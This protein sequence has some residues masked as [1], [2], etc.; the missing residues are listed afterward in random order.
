MLWQPHYNLMIDNNYSQFLPTTNIKIIVIALGLHTAA[1]L[2]QLCKNLMNNN[3]CGQFANVGQF[4][5]IMNIKRIV[6][7]LG[8]HINLFYSL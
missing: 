5:P 1:M 3:N 4:L 2:W 7:A 8:L 6:N